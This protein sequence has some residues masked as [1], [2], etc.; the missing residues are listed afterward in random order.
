VPTV[1]EDIPEH[2]LPEVNA[3]LAWFN[4]Q[5]DVVF[6]VTGI[7]DP[8][9]SL[10]GTGSRALKLVLCGGDRCEQRS[11]SVRESD[12]GYEI[13]F[14]EK[15]LPASDAIPA[16]LDP[17]PGALRGW[18]DNALASHDFVLLLFYRGFW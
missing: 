3:S 13:A 15:D 11:F 14:L 6:E 4:D 18:L 1:Q 2:L 5:E 10:A 8:D 7:V 16:A 9:E 17:P 12:H